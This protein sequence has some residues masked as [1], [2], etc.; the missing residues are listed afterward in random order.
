MIGGVGYLLRDL[1]RDPDPLRVPRSGLANLWGKD[2]R[3]DPRFVTAR[4]RDVSLRPVDSIKHAPTA[5]R[6]FPR[7]LADRRLEFSGIYEDG[8]VGESSWLELTGRPGARLRITGTVPP[9]VA[10]QRLRIVV[11]GRRL[12]TRRLAPGPF[13]LAVAA[14]RS[15]HRGARRVALRFSRVTRLAPPDGRPVSAR[16]TGVG[17]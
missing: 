7:G 4:V 11:D 17:F 9:R 8:W 3:L 2:I 1:G 10:D 13:S 14:P 15:E 6:A 16:L 5:V 12:A